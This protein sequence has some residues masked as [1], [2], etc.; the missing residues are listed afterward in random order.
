MSTAD[1]CAS[2]RPCSRSRSSAGRA[3]R[4]LS[5]LCSTAVAGR[6]LPT[7]AA[8]RCLTVEG[9]NDAREGGGQG[10]WAAWEVHAPCRERTARRPQ[11][12]Q[13]VRTACSLEGENVVPGGHGF[14]RRERSNKESGHNVVRRP[15]GVRIEEALDGN[16]WCGISGDVADP[17]ARHSR[18]GV[19]HSGASNDAWGATQRPCPATGCNGCAAQEERRTRGGVPVRVDVPSH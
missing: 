17:S 2:S 8:T 7:V 13:Q 15:T 3:R 16:L 4:V 5:S 11:L 10:R 12:W 1:V 14:D 6:K 18:R 19:H 9:C